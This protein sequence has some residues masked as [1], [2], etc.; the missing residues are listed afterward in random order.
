MVYLPTWMTL[1][2]LLS[3]FPYEYD[4]STSYDEAGRLEWLK[5]GTPATQSS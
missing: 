5:S 2:T 1:N 4:S 3:N